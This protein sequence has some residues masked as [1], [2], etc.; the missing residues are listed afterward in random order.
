MEQS[1]RTSGRRPVGMHAGRRFGDVLVSPE[2]DDELTWFFN[3]AGEQIEPPSIQG[4]LLDGRHPGHPWLLEARA[5]ALHA[6]RK[7]WG[8]MQNIGA[9]EGAVLE[10]LYTER[11]WPRALVRKLGHLTGVVEATPRVRA[12]HLGQRMLGRTAAA[13]TTEWLEALVAARSEELRGWRD[14]ALDASGRALSAYERA[15]GK[16]PSVVPQEDR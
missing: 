13:T 2:A 14:D 5:E 4:I 1:A 15:R 8:R 10:A 16:G 7:I 9:R 11:V 12:E 3:E 6:G